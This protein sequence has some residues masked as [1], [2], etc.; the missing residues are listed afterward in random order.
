SGA[1]RTTAVAIRSYLDTGKSLTP[2]MLDADGNGTFAALTDGRLIFRYL[3][4]IRGVALVG[5]SV[6]GV[7]ATRTTAAAIESYLQGFMPAAPLMPA[8]TAAASFTAASESPEAAAVPTS[9]SP[10]MPA[11]ATSPSPE[12]VGAPLA[13]QTA[14]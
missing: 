5:G 11:T 4:G 8:S 10:E 14:A 9:A 6:I 2:A 1:T 7:G 3:S 12:P 13:L